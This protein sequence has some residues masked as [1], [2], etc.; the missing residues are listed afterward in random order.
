[1]SAGQSQNGAELSQMLIDLLHPLITHQ[2]TDSIAWPELLELAKNNRVD[3]IL[4]HKFSS[5]PRLPAPIAK[6][7]NASIRASFL[8]SHFQASVL[9]SLTKTLDSIPWM[10]L[11]GPALGASLYGDLAL[12]PYADLDLLF[13]KDRLQDALARVRTEGFSAPP[14]SLDDR[15]YL[16]CHLHIY[17]VRHYPI[18]AVALE[19]HWDIDHPFSLL[20]IPIEEILSR[21]ETVEILGCKVPMPEP[22]DLLLLLAA[23]AVKHVVHLSHYVEQ[24]QVTAIVSENELLHFYDIALLLLVYRNRL[25]WEQIATR[26]RSWGLETVVTDCLKAVEMLWHGIPSEHQQI[27]RQ[28]APR[29]WRRFMFRIFDGGGRSAFKFQ[30]GAFFRPIRLLD[31]IDYLIPPPS[32]LN[33]RYGSKGIM[34]RLYHFAFAALNL[35]RAGLLFLYFSIHRQVKLGL[36]R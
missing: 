28:T 36:K 12:R 18:G 24:D 22:N 8:E 15:Y 5:D 4:Y 32:Y 6:A 1:M 16:N 34:P 30:Q 26:A 33:R 11:R 20:T 14:E 29:R 17:L 10:L 25:D 27:R 2:L 19:V 31:S 21:A 9:T 23:H 35:V 7:L 3:A 13:S